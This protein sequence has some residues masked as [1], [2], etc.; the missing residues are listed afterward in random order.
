MNYKKI[1]PE[2]LLDY[3]GS[4]EALVKL[5]KRA[6]LRGI[7]LTAEQ[8]YAQAVFVLLVENLETSNLKQNIK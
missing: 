4:G 3:F 2:R 6:H 1:T 5:N 8:A 7:T